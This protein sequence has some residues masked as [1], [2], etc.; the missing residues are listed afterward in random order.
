MGSKK[1]PSMT[2]AVTMS[3][4][5]LLSTAVPASYPAVRRIPAVATATTS[6]MLGK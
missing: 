2:M 3:P 1:T 6:P 5:F 4:I